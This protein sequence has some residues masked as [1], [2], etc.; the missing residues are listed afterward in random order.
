MQGMMMSSEAMQRINGRRETRGMRRD[1][2]EAVKGLMTV[3]RVLPEE[4]YRRVME[5][6][7]EIRP[8]EIFDAIVDEYGSSRA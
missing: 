2:H 5:T 8:G 4:H 7:E 1:W 6:D 3:M